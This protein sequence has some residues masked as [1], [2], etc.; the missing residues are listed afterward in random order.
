MAEKA[1]RAD[2][3]FDDD[4]KKTLQEYLRAS[5]GEV[6]RARKND[7]PNSRLVYNVD[8]SSCDSCYAIALWVNETMIHPK[9]GPIGRAP[10]DMP[11]RVR[12]LFDEAGAVFAT[13]PRAA[14]ALLRL[15]L[16]HLLEE[17]GENSKDINKA[18]N[19]MIDKGLDDEIAKIMHSLRIIGNESVHPGLISVD[20]EPYIAEALFDLLNQI[21]D[22]MII[23]PRKRSELWE[24][25]PANKRQSVEDKL[26]KRNSPQEESE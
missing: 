7:Y 4:D 11:A 12:T 14:A 9:S 25:L 21:V 15:A 1:E 23:K 19:S 16:Q 3:E 10:S 13:S 5:D 17:L 18:I 22:H 6:F 8:V 24:R 26:A 20:D 2:S